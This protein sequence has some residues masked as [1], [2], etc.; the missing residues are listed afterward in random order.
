[1]SDQPEPDFDPLAP[2]KTLDLQNLPSVEEL[3]VL[4]DMR[5]GM[6]VDLAVNADGKLYVFHEKPNPEE[7]EYV[8]YDIHGSRLVFIGKN[9]RIQD[10][11]MAVQ[12]AMRTHMKKAENICLV[13][14]KDGQPYQTHNVPFVIENHWT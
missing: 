7:I 5:S 10:I 1:M 9:G 12:D 4:P 3:P 2:K 13:Q 6:D 11:S 8:I 14:I